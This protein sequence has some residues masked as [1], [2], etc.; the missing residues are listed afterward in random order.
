MVAVEAL[1]DFEK[2][3]LAVST[4]FDTM[5]DEDGFIAYLATDSLKR[6]FKSD[7]RVGAILNDIHLIQ[8]GHK[9]ASGR[10]N[11]VEARD[12]A[13]ILVVKR[14]ARF[15]SVASADADPVA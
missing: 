3:P 7:H 6:M 12:M 2:D 15:G 9:P 11:I 14:L 1:A 8:S 10:T 13:R 5:L 4:L